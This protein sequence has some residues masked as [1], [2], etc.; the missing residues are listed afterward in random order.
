MY[1]DMEVRFYLCKIGHFN[2]LAVCA[3]P[4]RYTHTCMHEVVAAI[5][6]PLAHN[7]SIT[8]AKLRVLRIET[9]TELGVIL[10]FAS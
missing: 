1:S 8:I 4:R 9:N 3:Y 6:L 10:G 7:S 2:K 5:N